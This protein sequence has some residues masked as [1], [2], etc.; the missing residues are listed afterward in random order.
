M[1]FIRL[2]VA[3]DGSAYRGWQAQADQPTVQEAIERAIESVT[4]E[5]LRVVGAGRTDAGVHALGQGV[6]FATNSQLPADVLR[7]AL[8]AVTPHDIAVLEARDAPEGFNAIDAA[9]GK[10]YRYVIQDGRARDVFA[11]NYTWQIPGRLDVEAMSRAARP[12]IGEHDFAS[13]EAAGSKRASS[14]RHVRELLVERRTGP[15]PESPDRVVIE[16]EANGFLY[17]MVRIIVGTLAQVGRGVEAEAWPADVLAAR[18]RTRA[19]QTAPPQGLF[20]VRVDY[21]W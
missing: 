14:V 12:L 15:M 18:D 8:D 16:I 1:R 9:L 21:G 6:S 13:F 5:K 11:R 2:I 20:L 4:G 17:N 10:R 7:R 19:G 3:Y